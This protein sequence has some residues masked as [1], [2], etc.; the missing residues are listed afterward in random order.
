VY[1]YRQCF[2]STEEFF[3]AV[4]RRE[5][6]IRKTFIL[7]RIVDAR[8]FDL[9]KRSNS[10]AKVNI[11]RGRWYSAWLF[12]YNG[13]D[14]V[15]IPYFGPGHGLV[16]CVRMLVGVVF[17]CWN[18]VDCTYFCG[19]HFRADSDRFPRGF[20][21][22]EGAATVRTSID[23]MIWSGEP[24]VLF[25]VFKYECFPSYRNSCPAALLVVYVKAQGP[26]RCPR[27]FKTRSEIYW[28]R[29]CGWVD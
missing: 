8:V 25:L 7:P 27:M 5:T 29:Q 23:N 16:L 15:V 17:V 14:L 3:E 21:P 24:V 13:N 9:L 4:R 28:R 2:I 11:T 19:I 1:V 10:K 6:V 18:R 26:K 22:G 12:E 20:S